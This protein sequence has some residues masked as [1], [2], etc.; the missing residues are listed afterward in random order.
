MEKSLQKKADEIF[1]IVQRIKGYKTNI[2]KQFLMLGKDLLWAKKDGRYSAYG[3]HLN[4]F[5]D[6]LKEVKVPKSTAYHAM[7]VYTLFGLSNAL[8]DISERRLIRL[9]P[10]VNKENK[11]EWLEKAREYTDDAFEDELREARGVIPTDICGHDHICHYALAK[12]EDCGKVLE[13]NKIKEV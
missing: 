4:S 13:Y 7:N 2:V 8:Y 6:F 10:V 12:C 9:L 1:E 11:E 5:N 3:S